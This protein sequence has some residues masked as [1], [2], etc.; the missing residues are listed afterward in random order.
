MSSFDSTAP[1]PADKPTKPNKPYPE[2]PLTPHP[3]G[4]CCKKIRGKIHYFGPWDD[5]DGALTKYLEQ[6]DDLHAGRT[7][8]PASEVLTVKDLV[9]AFLN[10]KK[11]LLDAG[12]L[13]ALTFNDYKGA[14]DEI[15]AA[16]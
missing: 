5:P 2:F 9:N 14:C 11:A 6:K 8:R 10:H 13:S 4:C 7:P 12:E 1:A 3:A 16:F 15:V